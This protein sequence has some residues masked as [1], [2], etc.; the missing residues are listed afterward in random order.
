MKNISKR[1]VVWAIVATLMLLILLAMQ[2]S[3]E[4]QWNEAFAYGV[5]L[6]AA[7]GAYELWRWLKTQIHVYRLAFGA[8]LFGLLLVGWANGAI[9]I[10]GSEDNPANL[11]FLAVF[12]VALSGSLV[13]RF[14]P[15]GMAGTMLAAALV[16]LSVP[17]FA[18]FVWPAKTTWGEAGV[19]GVFVFNSFFSI[20]FVVSAW[21]FFRASAIA[22]K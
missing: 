10:I 16:Q 5:I 4:I 2:F 9:G 21:L 22:K 14:M 18:L 6:L 17:L 3:D 1:F 13:S 7:G 19:I 11:L 12:A 8:G 20:L 15:R